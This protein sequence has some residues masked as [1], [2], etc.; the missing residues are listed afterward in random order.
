MK[1]RFF[2]LI[3][4]GSGPFDLTWGTLVASYCKYQQKLSQSKRFQGVTFSST[5]P[6]IVTFFDDEIQEGNII[7]PFGTS[8]TLEVK[9]IV[10]KGM[11]TSV[12]LSLADEHTKKDFNTR[13]LQANT[14]YEVINSRKLKIWLYL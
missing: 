11:L 4:M 2:Y 13:F 3:G 6:F 5:E 12:K 7:R 10:S 9:E 1:R 8:Y 14:K